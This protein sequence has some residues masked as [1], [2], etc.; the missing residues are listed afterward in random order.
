[1]TEN[2]NAPQ[3]DHA[4]LAL[5]S[6]GLD[7]LLSVLFMRRLGY[8]VAPLFFRTPFFG[9]D[10]ARHTARANGFDIEVIDITEDHLAMLHNPRYG[11][12]RAANPCIDCH[13]L[14]FRTAAGLLPQY[15]AHFIIS[16]EVLGQRPMSQ[17]MDAMNAVGKLSGMKD[18]LVRPLCQKLMADTLPIRE[19]W[20]NKDEMLDFQGR[21]RKRQMELAAELGI[22]EFGN[23]GG[24]CLLTEQ[25]F[26][27]RVHDLLGHDALN[28][29]Q[30]EF[31]QFGR[32]FRL[33]DTCK[34]IIGKTADDNQAI[35]DL[36]T[37]ETVLKARQG[38]GP[39]GVL[40]CEGDIPQET[41]RLAASIVL[42]YSSKAADPS[43]VNYGLNYQLDDSVEVNR[44]TDDA[45]EPYW[46]K[47]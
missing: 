42:R 34:L 43:P 44:I 38:P 23:P 17:R 1:M 33:S 39:L 28:A 15:D 25:G 36:V 19:G 11:F 31:L 12:G 6:G 7:S 40:M 21:G 5:F 24:G 3:R 30:A 18:L 41:L 26:G 8:R 35:S 16:G 13:G 10:K 4:A 32:H 46:I 22:K 2:T 37:V 29:R 20:V 47:A 45:L 27:I 9:P 14:M